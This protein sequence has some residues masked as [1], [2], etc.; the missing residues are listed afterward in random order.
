M[1]NVRQI[2]RTDADTALM[3]ALKMAWCDA[4]AEH[5]VEKE[6]K[7]AAKNADS[8]IEAKPNTRRS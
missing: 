3:T 8:I 2:A 4:Y 5:Q 1:N 7:S 6:N